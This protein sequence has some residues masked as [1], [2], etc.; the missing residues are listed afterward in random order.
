V[1]LDDAASAQKA[2]ARLQEETILES[3]GN[4][5]FPFRAHVLRPA[6]I[7]QDFHPAGFALHPLT[8]SPATAVIQGICRRMLV[9]KDLANFRTPALLQRQQ[10][11]TETD[12]YTQQHP[13][14]QS[15][16][17]EGS[18]N[19]ESGSGYALA[20]TQRKREDQE[21]KALLDQNHDVKG[22]LERREGHAVIWETF[23]GPRVSSTV[24][25]MDDVPDDRGTEARLEANLES[26]DLDDSRA[27]SEIRRQ[28]LVL[29][30]G[31]EVG[32]Q[33]VD[34]RDATACPDVLHPFL[35]PSLPPLSLL[36]Q[37]CLIYTRVLVCLFS[38][39]L[40][41]RPAAK[42][43]A[44]PTT[45]NPTPRAIP[46]LPRRQCVCSGIHAGAREDAGDVVR[47]GIASAF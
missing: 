12:Q 16:E 1:I 37:P 11:L 21:R 43:T 18:V 17:P 7:Q 44:T 3:L 22:Y 13:S 40:P 4:H 5:N 41:L 25:P 14:T 20:T 29:V 27:V 35:P 34:L 46:M 28:V 9:L 19:H 23:K 42:L 32:V 45:L 38:P 33:G 47:V 31:L 2:V 8:K 30:L 10:Q 26:L 15:L 36:S 39:I 6:A 24:Q